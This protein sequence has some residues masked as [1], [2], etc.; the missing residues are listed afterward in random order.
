MYIGKDCKLSIFLRDK[1]AVSA[2]PVSDPYAIKILGIVTPSLLAVILAECSSVDVS[3]KFQTLPRSST[4][5][6]LQQYVG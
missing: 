3:L 2:V 6:G 4:F 1:A 5:Q